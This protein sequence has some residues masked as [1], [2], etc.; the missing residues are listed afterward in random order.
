[1]VKPR[2]TQRLKTRLWKHHLA[3]GIGSLLAVYLVNSMIQSDYAMYRWSM[4][5]GYVG[6][7]LL[8]ITLILGPAKLLS[9]KRY[10]RSNDL[11][12]DFGIW[13]AI[14]GL[15]HVVVGIQVHMGN[16]WLYF[17]LKDP[18]PQQLVLRGDL[19]GFANYTGLVAALILLFLLLLSNDLSMKKLGGK[20]WKNLQ[21]WSYGIFLFVIAHSIAYQV[22]EERKMLYLIIFSLLALI[23]VT[24]QLVGF[25]KWRSTN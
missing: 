11:R 5:S 20:R 8:V 2:K 14:I 1:M 21:R 15:I 7:A 25:F 24:L 9:G 17:F 3:L 23:T 4:A 10:P 12:R 13:S 16:P 18:F 22:I 19:F 6:L